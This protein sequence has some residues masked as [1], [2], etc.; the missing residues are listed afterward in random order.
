MTKMDKEKNFKCSPRGRFVTT[1]EGPI[2]AKTSCMYICRSF[3]FM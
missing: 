1:E 3:L 2:G